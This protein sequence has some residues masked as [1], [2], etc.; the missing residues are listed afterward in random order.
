MNTTTNIDA[1]YHF[2]KVEGKKTVFICTFSTGNYE[3][4]EI[5]KNKKGQAVCYFSTEDYTKEIFQ[6]KE[7][8]KMSMKN[9][10]VSK[11]RALI[12]DLKKGFGDVYTTKD[13]LL[14]SFSEDINGFTEAKVYIAKGKKNDYPFINMFLDGEFDDEIRR[15]EGEGQ[16]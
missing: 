4:F 6:R 13:L 12:A 10:H 11:V 16:D 5:R 8:W 2:K 14:F 7:K 3:P 9:F 15:I 1:I